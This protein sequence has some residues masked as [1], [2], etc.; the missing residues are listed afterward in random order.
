M[1]TSHAE[2]STQEVE[3]RGIGIGVDFGLDAI[4]AKSNA[5]HGMR[6]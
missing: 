4:E 2:R 6:L 1:H 3:K 5:R